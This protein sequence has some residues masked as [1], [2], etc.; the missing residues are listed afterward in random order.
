MFNFMSIPKQQFKR[1]KKCAG[2]IGLVC[3][4]LGFCVPVLTA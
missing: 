1:V 4:A 3:S 2:Q